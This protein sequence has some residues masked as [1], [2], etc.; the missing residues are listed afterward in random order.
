MSE[1]DPYTVLGVSPNVDDAALAAVYR[2]LLK[3]YHPDLFEGPKAEA[4]R[5]TT[6]IIQAYSLLRNP[7]ARRAYDAG[8]HTGGDTTAS[9]AS[10]TNAYSNDFEIDWNAVRRQRKPQR[11]P[12][13]TLI[14]T[15]LIGACVLL[16][17]WLGDRQGSPTQARLAAEPVH[18]VAST[19]NLL[20]P[21]APIPLCAEIPI[22]GQILF[23]SPSLAKG[24]H[25][26]QIKNQT[27]GNALVKIRDSRTRN[28]MVTLFVEAKSEGGYSELPDGSYIVQYALLSGLPADCATPLRPYAV[29]QIPEPFDAYVT[30]EE[31]GR[32][33]YQE[34]TYTIFAEASASGNVN[35]S[36]ITRA[37]FDQN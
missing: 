36:A 17:A 31:D 29:E 3:K 14:A 8:R 18:L 15:A 26:L 24:R 7:D 22:N 2:A 13:N 12:R 19:P 1:I 23:R 4:E 33:Y 35:P 10:R 27:S 30:R 16:L 6:A 28:L 9:R 25:S 5:K 32:R 11:H 34:L 20:P 37:Q 21:P